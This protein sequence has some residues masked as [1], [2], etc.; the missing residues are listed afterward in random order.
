[1]NHPPAAFGADMHDIQ[2]SPAWQDLTG[3]FPTPY[4]L[5]FG[6]YIDWYNPFTNKIAGKLILLLCL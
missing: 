5:V 1:M 2:D 4:H 3:L 6:I